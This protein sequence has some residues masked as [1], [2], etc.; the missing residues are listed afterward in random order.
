M[1][2]DGKEKK[3]GERAPPYI[4]NTKEDPRRIILIHTIPRHTY[5]TPL[6]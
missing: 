1:G 4:Q 2:Y 5:Q 6:Y 3:E